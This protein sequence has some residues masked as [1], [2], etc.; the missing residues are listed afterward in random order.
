MVG[1]WYEA[2]PAVL[3]SKESMAVLDCEVLASGYGSCNDE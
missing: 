1:L 2:L 3:S